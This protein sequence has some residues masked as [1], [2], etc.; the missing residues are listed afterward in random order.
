M[1]RPDARRPST[2]SRRFAY[3]S[4]AVDRLTVQMETARQ[5]GDRDAERA[6]R[7]QLDMLDE[8]I[9]ETLP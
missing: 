6:F 2:R 7:R 8:G 1:T 3:L 4:A 9:P 5:A